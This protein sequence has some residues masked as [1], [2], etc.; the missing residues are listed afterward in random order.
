MAGKKKGAISK[1]LEDSDEDD[2][3]DSK[4][5]KTTAVLSR[6]KTKKMGALA[7]KK[8]PRKA[9]TLSHNEVKE[10]AHK[11]LPAGE[12]SDDLDRDENSLEHS[13][14]RE[15]AAEDQQSEATQKNEVPPLNLADVGPPCILCGQTGGNRLSSKRI[16][17]ILQEHVGMEEPRKS[18]TKSQGS[19]GKPSGRS[20]ERRQSLIGRI[21]SK[22]FG[23]VLQEQGSF[24]EERYSHKR[25]SERIS[26]REDNTTTNR[27]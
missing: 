1:G 8:G 14:I 13:E 19:V 27:E 26:L 11:I 12:E 2:Y 15:E 7:K 21:G 9:L 24:R 25:S 4:L 10:A 22:Q 18:V 5:A 6:K 17:S 20:S 23:L 16:R 3:D